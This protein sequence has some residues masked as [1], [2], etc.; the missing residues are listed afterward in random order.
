LHVIA[1]EYEP[2][3]PALEKFLVSQGR[4]KFLKPLYMKLN[5]T[6]ATREMGRDIYR[7]AR[8]TY[9]PISVIAIDRILDWQA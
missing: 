8:P 6:P 4:N 7:R 5:D 9:H 2:A 1:N 3:Y